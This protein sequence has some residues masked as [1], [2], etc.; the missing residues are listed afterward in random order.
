MWFSAWHRPSQLNKWFKVH[1]GWFFTLF[2]PLW[3]SLP[4]NCFEKWYVQLLILKLSFPVSR[5]P[6]QAFQVLRLQINRPLIT[7]LVWF[8]PQSMLCDNTG[9]SVPSAAEI[10]SLPQ[11]LVLAWCRLSLCPLCLCH[12]HLCLIPSLVKNGRRTT[13]HHRGY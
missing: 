4:G 6:T 11:P 9:L 10:R 7:E 13:V 8:L 5:F 2:L 1:K 3:L 12:L